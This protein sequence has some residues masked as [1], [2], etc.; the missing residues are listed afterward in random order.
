MLLENNVFQCYFVSLYSAYHSSDTFY[1]SACA[2]D[3]AEEC[4]DPLLCNAAGIC[5][6]I[7]SI[8]IYSL[9]THFK[10][11]RASKGNELRWHHFFPCSE[12]TEAKPDACVNPT[13]V[14]SDEGK[15][16]GV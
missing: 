1:H 12:C 2:G 9:S 15:C 11:T 16:V 13:G 4:T 14:C 5:L 10:N 3:A 7:V 8:K 6:G